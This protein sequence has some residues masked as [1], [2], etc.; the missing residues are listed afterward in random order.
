MDMAWPWKMEA[1]E[2]TQACAD[3]ETVTKYSTIFF[4]K[5]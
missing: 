1:K 2:S 5:F 4:C 3:F